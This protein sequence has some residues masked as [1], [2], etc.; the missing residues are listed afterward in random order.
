MAHEQH[1]VDR[2]SGLHWCEVF[3][4]GSWALSSSISSRQGMIAMLGLAWKLERRL[5]RRL[6][7]MIGRLGGKH[8]G[9]AEPFTTLGRNLRVDVLACE[10]NDVDTLMR[11]SLPG[12]VV[13]V[14]LSFLPWSTS[15]ETLD[16][17]DRTIATI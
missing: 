4:L 16:P 14:K 2:G 10:A 6:D 9:G 3:D 15:G 13:E 5:L 11:H 17:C 1:G 7:V 8:L 12:G